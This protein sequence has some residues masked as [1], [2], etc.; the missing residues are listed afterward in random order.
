MKLWVGRSVPL[1]CL[2]VMAAGLMT[3]AAAQQITDAGTITL[4]GRV[5]GYVEVRAG[6][7]ATLTGNSGGSITNNKTK[8][9]PLNG[10]TID[11]GELGP[12]NTNSFVKATVPLRLRSNTS[13]TLSMS[14]TGFT[15]SN[16]DMIQPSD[17]GFG[18]ANIS[19]TD[20]AVAP[21][22]DTIAAG[23][24]GD[25]S[26]DPDANPATDRWDYTT[27]KSLSTY[28]TS[29]AILSGPVIMRPVVPIGNTS[30]LTLNTFFVVKP[31]FFAA[32]SFSTT[33]TFTISTP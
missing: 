10:L 5:S 15:N 4:S 25:P 3:I 24:S 32:S 13:Y 8:G 21:G 29:R 11:L 19:R 14:T 30:G 12:S 28:T 27:A 26:L 22:T 23:V 9:Q 20:P 31:Q 33:V 16:A 2:A 6:G 17:I 18:L 7:S 1:A